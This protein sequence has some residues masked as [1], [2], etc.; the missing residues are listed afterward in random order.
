M[1]TGNISIWE[2]RSCIPKCVIFHT[3]IAVCIG[4]SP[5]ANGR[6]LLKSSHMGIPLR[7]MKLCTYLKASLDKQVTTLD[8]KAEGSGWMNF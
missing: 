7:I 3:G 6:G 2:I 8:S 4:G 5:Y 1:L